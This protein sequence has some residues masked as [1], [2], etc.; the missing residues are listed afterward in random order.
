MMI[1]TTQV[2]S[3]LILLL[4]LTIRN[5][6]VSWN[7]PS[8]VNSRSEELLSAEQKK[9]GVKM[10]EERLEGDEMMK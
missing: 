8:F 6:P 9:H 5:V 7:H 2:F 1:K 3:D 10:M 4:G